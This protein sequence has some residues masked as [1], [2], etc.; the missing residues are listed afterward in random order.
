VLHT[1]VGDCAG[2]GERV[3]LVAELFDGRGGTWRDLLA[4]FVD[5][6]EGLL[7][8]LPRGGGDVQK[9]LSVA[10]LGRGNFGTYVGEGLARGGEGGSVNRVER[11]NQIVPHLFA[12]T[13]EVL[14]V[15]GKSAV[16]FDD[17]QSLGSAIDVRVEHP[18]R[19]QLVSRFE[20][21]LATGVILRS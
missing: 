20:R 14:I 18:E 1:I 9:G 11:G 10:L 13:H 7:H 16:V 3:S 17:S 15:E 5:H 19:G 12:A 21:K 4:A 6:A 8:A 2:F